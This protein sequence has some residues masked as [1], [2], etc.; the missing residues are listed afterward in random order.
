MDSPHAVREITSCLVRQGQCSSKQGQGQRWS[1]PR[2][3]IFVLELCSRSAGQFS[4]IRSTRLRNDVFRVERDAT[5][6][7]RA[8]QL[9]WS[10]RHAGPGQRSADTAT[11]VETPQG[12]LPSVTAVHG[13]TTA[14]DPPPTPPRPLCVIDCCCCCTGSIL[15]SWL[16]VRGDISHHPPPAL[17]FSDQWRNKRVAEGQLHG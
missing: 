1:R 9:T 3:E 12:S 13:G 2:P 4:T 16:K 7:H 15:I 6:M 17:L 11:I 14:A 8:N 5:P 10:Q